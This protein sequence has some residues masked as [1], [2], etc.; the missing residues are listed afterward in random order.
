MC[1]SSR[2]VSLKTDGESLG[3]IVDM[4]VYYHTPRIT[5]CHLQDIAECKIEKTPPIQSDTEVQR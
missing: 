4:F 3:T 2:L 5:F 1:V